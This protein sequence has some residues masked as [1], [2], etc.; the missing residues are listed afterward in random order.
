MVFLISTN[1]FKTYYENIFK[2]L[3]SLKIF[4]EMNIVIYKKNT[5]KRLKI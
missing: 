1:E 2:R 4:V 5:M 3:T